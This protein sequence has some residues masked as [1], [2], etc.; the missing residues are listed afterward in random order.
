[1]DKV[2][3]EPQTNPVPSTS[4]AANILSMSRKPRASRMPRAKESTR[5]NQV[6][7]VA[8]APPNKQYITYTKSILPLTQLSLGGEVINV[9]QKLIENV[10]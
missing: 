8:A 4:S 1:M 9:P 7:T 5:N 10:I 6:N 2:S 3:F